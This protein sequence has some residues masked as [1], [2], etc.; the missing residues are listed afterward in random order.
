MLSQFLTEH[1]GYLIQTPVLADFG[2]PALLYL[3]FHPYRHFAS[4]IKFQRVVLHY[5]T[6]FT[7]TYMHGQ[8]VLNCSET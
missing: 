1:K 3:P 6:L 5:H 7:A 2:E 8:Q 4:C